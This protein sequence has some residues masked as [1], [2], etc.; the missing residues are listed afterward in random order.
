MEPPSQ[1]PTDNPDLRKTPF[2]TKLYMPHNFSMPLHV[3]SDSWDHS[4]VG[5]FS[6]EETS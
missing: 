4:G 6:R 2:S 5:M 1:K 3:E